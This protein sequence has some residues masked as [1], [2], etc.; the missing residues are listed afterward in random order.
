MESKEV[1][2]YVFSIFSILSVA[3]IFL[4][5]ILHYNTQSVSNLLLNYRNTALII[6]VVLIAIAAATTLPISVVLVAGIFIFSFWEALLYAFLGIYLGSIAVYFFAKHTG[7]D[8]INEYTNLKGEKLKALHKL[9]KEKSLSLVILLNAV[10]FIPSNIGHIIGGILNMN[11]LMFL[12]AITIG[13]FPNVVGVALIVLGVYSNYIYFFIGIVII[14]L[15]TAV[16][17]YIFRKHIRE[18]VIIAFSKKFYKKIR[19]INK[20]IS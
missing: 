17:L 14:V 1:K 19:K 18:L 9:I 7:K 2:F 11:F 4:A 20:E 10:Y 16:P 3:L 12:F 6:Y 13:N 15:N 8:F 5:G